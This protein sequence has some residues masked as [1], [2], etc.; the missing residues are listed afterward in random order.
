[1]ISELFKISNDLNVISSR[2]PIGVE[3]IY[4]PF[5]ILFL[6][7]SGY[8]NLIKYNNTKKMKSIF[9]F[10]SLVIIIFY[11]FNQAA[12]SQ[13]KIRIGL[14]VPLSGEYSDI[15]HSILNSLKEYF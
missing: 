12:F 8:I 15:G 7:I 1:M 3:T 14:I 5:F 10:L 2:F 11:S 9:K 4:K 6:S 13:E